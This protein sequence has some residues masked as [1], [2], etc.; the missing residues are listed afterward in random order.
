MDWQELGKLARDQQDYIVSLRRYFHVHAEISRQE[1]HTK[2]KIMEE[3]KGMGIPCETIPHSNALIAILKGGRPG[4]N[5]VLRADMDALPLQEDPENLKGP[6]VCVS[7][8]P[9]AM[10][11]CGHDAHM[12]M[13]LGAMKVLKQV[14]ADIP[15]TVYCCFEEAEETYYGWKV[16]LKELE[17][18]PIDE[19]F[20][21]HVYFQL[22]AGK[23]NIQPGPRMAGNM[24]IAFTLKG[25]SGHGSR[26]DQS[27]NPINPAIHIISQL[28]SA[29]NNM[30]N[31]EQ[32]ETLAI[33]QLQAGTALNIIPDSI[34]VGGTSRF[35]SKEEREKAFPMM[36][37]II[38][39]TT[40]SF[41][42]EVSYGDMHGQGPV[43]VVNDPV[44]ATKVHDTVAAMYGKEIMGD[45]PK[46]YAS[47]GFSRY[48]EKYPGALGLVGIRNKEYGSGAAHHNSRFDMDE[49]GLY[50][51]TAAH[52]AFVFGC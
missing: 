43:P 31:V 23:I 36:N 37:R 50:L 39:N 34:F 6:K 33:C 4:K 24:R 17:K 13:L 51:G 3:L 20:A 48:M 28:N 45:C 40:K 49:K 10:H 38:E 8:N 11:A 22:D 29:Y 21:L 35:F 32:T 19:V 12:A 14:Q 42:C 15:G 30:L 47:E 5:K 18:Y 27:I 2:E 16:M 44:I 46:W 7:Q 26:P 25:R 41:G 52:L 9:G 1:V